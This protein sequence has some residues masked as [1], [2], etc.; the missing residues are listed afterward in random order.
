M[1]I[2]IIEASSYLFAALQSIELGKVPA[3]RAIH[4]CTAALVL[5]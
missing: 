3:K 1:A 4:S 5:R 2:S